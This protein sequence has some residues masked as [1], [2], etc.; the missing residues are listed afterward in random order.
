MGPETEP[1]AQ[2]RLFPLDP[3]KR[4]KGQRRVVPTYS[5]EQRAAFRR[6]EER[7]AQ[8]RP[9]WL[10]DNRKLCAGCG[11]VI[12]RE[13]RNCGRRWCPLVHRTWLRDRE[14]VI[15]RALQEHGG[16]FL[17][18]AITQTHRP[19]WWDCDGSGHPRLPCSGVRGCRVR[20]EVVERENE[21][22]SKR[23]RA[24]LNHARTWALRGMKR[25]GYEVQASACILVQTVEPQSRGLDHGHIVLGHATKVEKA[26]ARFFVDG[27]AR[28][29]AGHGLGF[30]DR[31]SHALWKQR[32][33]QGPGQAERAARYLSKYVS[34]E[35]AADWLRAKAGQRVFYVAPWLSRTAGASMRIARLGR[36]LWASTHGYCERPRCTDEELEAV[37]KFLAARDGPP[38][39]AP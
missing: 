39:R 37:M 1:E 23:R 10:P 19:G 21:L 22:F 38:E 26:F 28:F 12:H 31:Y 7:I 15:R 18:I 4:T 13:L 17:V 30:V 16:P 35:R 2:L 3:P 24:L 8:I 33:Y 11:K 6:T 29:A 20:A 14:A 25:A 32:D 27:L 5:D 9:S 34:K 36:R